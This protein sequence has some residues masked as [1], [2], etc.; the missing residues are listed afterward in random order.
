MPGDGEWIVCRDPRSFQNVG[1]IE[2]LRSRTIDNAVT[3]DAHVT[4]SGPGAYYERFE[5]RA[6]VE[7]L[8]EELEDLVR[9]LWGLEARPGSKA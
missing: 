4:V 6:T 5:R 2:L 9:K 8:E 1:R 3:W 7:V